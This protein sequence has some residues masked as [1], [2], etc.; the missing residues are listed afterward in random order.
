VWALTKAGKMATFPKSTA[1]GSR[2]PCIAETTPSEIST[3]P[4]APGGEATGKI[5]RARNR[6][7]F[8]IL[9]QSVFAVM[10]GQLS[11]T[12]LSQGSVS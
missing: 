6:L 8:T 5:Q 7:V 3:T 10:F 1:R 11:T 4:F 12:A 2:L 9:S